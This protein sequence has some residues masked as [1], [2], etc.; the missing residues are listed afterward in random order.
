MGPYEPVTLNMNKKETTKRLL[1]GI[2]CMNCN[3]LATG[4]EVIP[5]NKAC[6]VDYYNKLRPLSLPKTLMCKRWEP[7]WNYSHRYTLSHKLDRGE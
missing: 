3:W 2:G 6:Y 7:P 1:K 5:K 4:E